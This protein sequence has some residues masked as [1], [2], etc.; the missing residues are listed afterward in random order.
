MTNEYV[1]AIAPEI[2]AVVNAAKVFITNLGNDPTKLPLTS[3]PALAIFL[4][5]VA[6]QGVPALNAEWSLVQKESLDKLDAVLAKFATP[7]PVK[8]A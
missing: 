5:T 8:P 4:N 6:L 1:Q 3:G 7:A 2:V